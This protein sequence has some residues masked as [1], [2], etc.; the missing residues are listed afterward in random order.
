M[1]HR[2]ESVRILHE[3]L[4]G[5]SVMNEIQRMNDNDN[6]T[7]DRSVTNRCT[8]RLYQ[9]LTECSS[10]IQ[11]LLNC[12]K[13]YWCFV[14]ISDTDIEQDRPFDIDDEQFHSSQERTD[15][16]VNRL[17]AHVRSPPSGTSYTRK[18]IEQQR[19]FFKYAFDRLFLPP[20]HLDI[21]TF[22]PI[23]LFRED[24]SLRLV[25]MLKKFLLERTDCRLNSVIESETSVSSSFLAYERSS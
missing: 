3:F 22:M 25:E 2:R 20:R 15:D 21:F 10:A 6:G 5:P 12:S 4:L 19:R 17:M 24:S 1:L 18:Q 9:H 11:L 14:P 7:I 13:Y 8:S 16:E 23:Y